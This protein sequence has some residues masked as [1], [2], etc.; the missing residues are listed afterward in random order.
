[1]PKI[2][3]V[4]FKTLVRKRKKVGAQRALNTGILITLSKNSYEPPF[5]CNFGAHIDFS[6]G[7]QNFIS[8]LTFGAQLMNFPTWMY[9]SEL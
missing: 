7:A 9:S 4:H 3:G 5:Q 1:M 2:F 6:L 8:R